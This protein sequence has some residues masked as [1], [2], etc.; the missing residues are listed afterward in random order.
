MMILPDGE[1]E[2]S[3]VYHAV[4]LNMFFQ[5]ISNL[6]PWN[7]LIFSNKYFEA[8]LD[9]VPE[10]EN[11]IAYFTLI[12]MAMKFVFLVSGIS[13][14]KRVE[15][16]SQIIWSIVGNTLVFT[17]M[18]A[19]CVMDLAA[20]TFYYIILVLGSLFSAFSEAAFLTTLTYFPAKYTQS[21]LVGHGFAGVAGAVLH[22]VSTIH[23]DSAA[24][25]SFAMVY[26]GITT[27]VILA[28]LGMFY[29]LRSL[30]MFKYYFR[31]GRGVVEAQEEAEKLAQATGIPANGH[32]TTME[33]FKEIYDLFFT[34]LIL[35]WVNLT[36]S[37]MLVVMT[38][39]VIAAAKGDTRDLFHVVAFLV[40]SIFDLIGKAVPAISIFAIKKMPFL[41]IACA[42]VVL[43][44]LFLVGNVQMR[45]YTLPFNPLYQ[46]D[47][48]FMGIMALKALSGGYVGTLC[49]MWSPFRVKAVNRGKAVTIMVFAIGCGL[50]LGAISALGLK[51]ILRIISKPKAPGVA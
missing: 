43:L 16:D 20:R 35:V 33:V 13:V 46:N 32:S 37:P 51:Y 24:S 5:G 40:S 22:I 28:S 12:F 7:V 44:P 21:Y 31:K 17:L 4:Y 30:N 10:A 19:A 14:T 29:V 34:V 45:N 50:L 48:I 39:S 47:Y 2:H 41:A 8:R 3:D 6:L 11:F 26:F 15:P 27:G 36:I 38:D 25:D 23:S 42:R 18:G 9:T 1:G 49:M